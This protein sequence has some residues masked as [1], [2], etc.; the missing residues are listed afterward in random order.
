MRNRA[1]R[2]G[3]RCKLFLMVFNGVTFNFNIKGFNLYL[4]THQLSQSHHYFT[5]HRAIF[6]HSIQWSLDFQ[7]VPTLFKESDPKD[8]AI[9]V[10]NEFKLQT[11]DIFK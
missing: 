2:T 5:S 11:D 8:I 4:D 1:V 3:L 9:T 6:A 10:L 7:I